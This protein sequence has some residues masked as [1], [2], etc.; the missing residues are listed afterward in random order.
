M[1]KWEVYRDKSYR[2]SEWLERKLIEV[3]AVK[4]GHFV[5][6]SGKESD[7]YV[8]IKYASTIPGVLWQI[9]LGMSDIVKERYAGTE[10]VAGMEL[11]AVPIAAAV[12]LATGLPYV[13]IRKK[14]KGH[15]TGGLLEGDFRKGM[16]VVVVEDVVTTG[17]SVLKSV[18]G[19]EE[20]G[21]EPLGSIVVVDREEGAAEKLRAIDWQSLTTASKLK[22]RR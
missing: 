10:L 22:S 11:G 13:M 9:A 3:G 5:L 19:L 8:D 18:E 15:G 20:E 2:G 16:K 6:T 1:D 4:F 12:S 7:Y 17:G 14:A 21:L